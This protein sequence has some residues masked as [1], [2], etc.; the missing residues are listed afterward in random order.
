[1]TEIRHTETN[2]SGMFTAW[3]EGTQ[4]GEMTYLRQKTTPK[5]AAASMGTTTEPAADTS[6]DTMIINHTQTFAG[7]EGQGIARQMVMAAVE[8]ARQNRCKITPVCS[9]AV[10]VL[11]L[12][13]EY[14]DILV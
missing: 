7:F 1:M 11:T 6:P 13:D 9:Y 2:D 12:T 3:V 10:A 14:K 5:D 8:F 4:A